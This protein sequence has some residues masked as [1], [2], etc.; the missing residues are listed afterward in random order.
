MRKTVAAPEMKRRARARAPHSAGLPESKPDQKSA[1]GVVTA[2]IRNTGTSSLNPARRPARGED[3]A[4][5]GEY[6]GPVDAGYLRGW[7]RSGAVE[8]IAMQGGIDLEE[9][10]KE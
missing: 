4:P 2:R 3:I 6:E 7:I 8:L 1:P 10:L 9:F 5:G